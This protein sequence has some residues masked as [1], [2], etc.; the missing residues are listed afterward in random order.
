MNRLWRPS[1]RRISVI[2]WVRGKK[3]ENTSK[4]NKAE[5]G[6][7]LGIWG[8]KNL[9]VSFST[10]STKG[11]TWVLKDRETEV[12][13][14]A[15]FLMCTP[16]GMLILA[17]TVCAALSL[18]LSLGTTCDNSTLWKDTWPGFRWSELHKGDWLPQGQSSLWPQY[19]R[20]LSDRPG[21]QSQFCHQSLGDSGRSQNL[22]EPL[23]PQLRIGGNK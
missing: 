13:P 7:Y 18:T 15:S 1:K 3:Y 5:G 16:S 23:K 6:A 12:S 4:V 8:T 22:L 19:T 11:K 14:V 10:W 2:S 9:H 17:V 21:F 20:V